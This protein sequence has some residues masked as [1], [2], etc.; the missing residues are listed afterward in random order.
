MVSAEAARRSSAAPSTHSPA[1]AHVPGVPRYQAPSHRSSRKEPSPADR[2]SPAS[3]GLELGAGVGDDAA[4][5]DFE[6]IDFG[7]GLLAPVRFEVADGDVDARGA[8]RLRLVEHAVGFADAGGISQV[9]F[10]LAGALHGE[11][12]ST[13]GSRFTAE[14]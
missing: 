2:T 12:V 5:H 10:E 4:R 6:A 9:D 11:S 8:E 3:S 13:R 1:S 14:T 7:D